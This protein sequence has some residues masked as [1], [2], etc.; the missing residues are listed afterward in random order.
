KN[1][2]TVSVC[3][4]NTADVSDLDITPVRARYVRL[5]I[6]DPGKDHKARIGE[7]EIYGKKTAPAPGKSLDPTVETG[8]E[9]MSKIQRLPLLYPYGTKK[10]RLISY[11]ASGG[12]GFG[13]LINTFKKYVDEHGDVVIFDAYGPGCL[14]RQQMNIWGNKGIGRLSKTIRIKYYFDGEETPRI[15]APADDF[16][17]GDYRPIDTPFA[18]KSSRQFAINYYPFSFQKRLKVTLSDTSITRLLKANIDEPQNW[19][20]YDYLTYPAGT[21][22]TTWSPSSPEPYENWAK[23]Q[24]EDLGK[25][26]QVSTGDQVLEDKVKIEPG[27]SVVIFDKKGKGAI[28]SIHLKLEPFNAETFYHTYIRMRWD[29]L[30]QPAVDVPMSYFFGGGGWKDQYKDKTLRTLLFGFDSQAHTFYCYFPM[31]YFEKAKIE[32]VNE[33]AT[34]IDELQYAIGVKT[35]ID[36]PRDNTGYFMAKVTKDSCSGGKK[37]VGS[38]KVYSKPFETA[39]KE[40]GRGHVVAVN[41]FSGNYWEDGDEFTYVDGSNTPQIHGDGTE[42]DFNQGWAGG[43]YQKPLWGAL[44]MGVKGSYRIHLDE[45]YIFYDSIDMRFENTNARYR[46]NS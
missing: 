1:W 4:N 11:D 31:P 21:A 13:L 15:D 8:F 20:Q 44:Q 30:G 46:A 35:L 41:M 23:E 18:F 37:V 39:F 16:F 22:V 17:N 29:D 5:R 45:P 25:D 12:N 10:N 36:Y 3:L 2:K 33:S 28:A 34:R 24:W 42:D 27:S 43:K 19:Y 38:L 40:T 7:I 14:Y 26:P 32:I 6:I 9:E